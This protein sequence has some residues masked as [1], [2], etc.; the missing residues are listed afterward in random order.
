MSD[1]RT[2]VLCGHRGNMADA[3][4]NT[5]LGFASAE[6]VG[7]DEIEF[8]VRVTLD[9]ELVIVHDRTFERTAASSTPYLHTPIEQLT[10]DQVRS[11]DLGEGQRVP[12]FEET[13]DAT[14]VLL[15]VE[16]KALDAARPLARFLK[17]RPEADLNRCLFT[18]FDP[19]SLREFADEWGDAPMGRGL[20]YHTHDVTSNWRDG[21]RNLGVTMV[22]IPLNQLTRPLVDGLHDEGYL[23]AGSLLESHGDVRRII[24]LDVDTS[25]S[26]APEY[27]RRQVLSSAAFQSHFASVKEQ[28]ALV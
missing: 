10:F 17:N 20:G 14:S 27:A 12:T 23:V 22:L 7:V 1:L 9:G 26:N 5:L 4:E 11:I 15:Q 21:V 25:A 13:L 3:P 16:I 19:L 8:D 28:H 24:E 6:R 2:F 18:S